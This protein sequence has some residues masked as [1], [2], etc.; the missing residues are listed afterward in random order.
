MA[1]RVHP[2]SDIVPGSRWVSAEG[3]GYAIVM[4]AAGGHVRL[5]FTDGGAIAEQRLH[6]EQFRQR[7]VA[8]YDSRQLRSKFSMYMANLSEFHA[9]WC[10]TTRRLFA[11]STTRSPADAHIA[12]R[13]SPALPPGVILVGTYSQPY[14]PDGFLADLNDA[15]AGSSHSAAA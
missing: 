12:A 4:C 14:K 2:A 1:Y 15:I 7:F 6:H 11:R 9:F 10:L 8:P 13:G 5:L 3:R